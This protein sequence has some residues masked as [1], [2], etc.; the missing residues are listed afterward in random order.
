MSARLIEARLKNYSSTVLG[1]SHDG[2]TGRILWCPN[3]SSDFGSCVKLVCKHPEWRNRL[4]EMKMYPRHSERWHWIVDHWDDLERLYDISQTTPPDSVESSHAHHLLKMNLQ[5]T[6]HHMPLYSLSSLPDVKARFDLGTNSPWRVVDD[7]W[8]GA[9]VPVDLRWDPKPTSD[10]DIP[11][12][13][14][15]GYDKESIERLKERC[16]GNEAKM[17]RLSLYRLVDVS[18]G[19]SPEIRYVDVYDSEMC[20]VSQALIHS[21][22][23]PDH[24]F[25]KE[26]EGPQFHWIVSA[27]LVPGQWYDEGV[28]NE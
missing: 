23:Y 6:F 24:P 2:S 25:W 13:M 15:I 19:S 7:G 4:L 27:P 14:G 18:T 11:I 22:P 26:V 3:D 10:D 17:S 9:F 21:P 16:I 12:C 8:Y 28:L 1:L 5:C 20:L